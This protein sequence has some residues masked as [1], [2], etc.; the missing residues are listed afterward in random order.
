M[1][2]LWLVDWHRRE[3]KPGYWRYKSLQGL[4]TELLLAE[5]DAIAGLVPVGRIEDVGRGTGIFRY[6]FPRQDHK[7][8]EGKD[9]LDPRIG[10]WG[11]GCG[12]RRCASTRQPRRSTCDA[13]RRCRTGESRF[14]ALGQAASEQ[15]AARQGSADSPTG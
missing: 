11:A 10:D 8:R 2:P 13:R 15:L 14:A 5:N 4:S 1:A 12:P 7:L 9:V 3:D 6:A